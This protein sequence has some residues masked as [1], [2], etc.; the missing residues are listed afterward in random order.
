MK[1]HILIPIFCLFIASLGFAQKNTFKIHAVPFAW[2]EVRLGYERQIAPAISIQGNFGFFYDKIPSI[3]HDIEAVENY[4]ETYDIQN[5]LRGFS[6]SVDLRIHF[7]T[8]IKGFYLAP[9]LKYHKYTFLTPA[10]FDYNLDPDEF[11][12][13]TPEQQLVASQVLTD[14][15]YNF[16]VTG[17]LDGSITQIGGGIG[18]GWQFILGKVIVIDFNPIGIGIEHNQV[19]I[20]L[21]SD[22]DVDYNK[23]LPYVQEEVRNVEYFGDKV[24]VTAKGNT[25]HMSA[26]ILLP[27]YRGSISIGFAF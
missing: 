8:D 12:D 20:D 4:F 22:L 18:I 16:E 15:T 3:I 11:V 5:T 27:T 19:E 24:D 9:Y 10:S 23:W 6:S 13:L 14:G 21:T 2:G 7:G 17:T 25:I 26:P 1:K